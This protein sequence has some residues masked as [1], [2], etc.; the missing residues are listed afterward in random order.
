MFI[1][2]NII[3]IQGAGTDEEAIVE[4]LCTRS[5]QQIR[6]VR[7]AYRNCKNYFWFSIKVSF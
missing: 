5:N 3:I 6:D 4:I 2:I 1:I 7:T